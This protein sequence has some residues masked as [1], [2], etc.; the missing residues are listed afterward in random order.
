MIERKI[1]WRITR[2]CNLHCKHCLAGYGNQ[3][4][5]DLSEEDQVITLMKVIECNVSRITWTGGEPTLCKSLPKLLSICHENSIASV[6]TT[7]GLAL[8]SKFYSILNSKLDRLRFSFD[9]LE[10]NHNLIRGGNYFRKTMLALID[11]ES[12]GF[13]I[14][15][16]ISVMEQNIGDILELIT[17][18]EKLNV[19]KIVLL[20]L[21]SR[22][23][24][25]DNKLER[26]SKESYLELGNS[27]DEFKKTHPGIAIQ[28]N[29][30]WDENDFYIVVESDGQVFLCSENTEDRSFGLMTDI[31][32]VD[33][34][35]SALESQT[36]SHRVAII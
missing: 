26:P 1:C 29:N 22:E 5:S 9:G 3:Q 19:K 7:H 32:G 10:T 17:S 16:N 33:S 24:A 30:Y 35:N 12:R 15:A 36:L 11:A 21:M 25:Q 34:L 14:E 6:I 8:T 20:N 2:F 18:L 31:T 27:L 13:T 23:S 28:L 4:I